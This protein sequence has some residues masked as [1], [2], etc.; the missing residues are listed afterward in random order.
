MVKKLKKNHLQEVRYRMEDEGL[1]YCFMHYSTWDEIQDPQF[2][3]LRQE[4][5]KAFENLKTYVE[6]HSARGEW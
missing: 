5:I 1:D 3:Q 6:A 2:H 4:Y